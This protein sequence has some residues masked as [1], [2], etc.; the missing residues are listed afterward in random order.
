MSLSLHEAA[1]EK[2]DQAIFITGSARSG[3]T[4]MGK[5]IH[6]LQGV[7]YSFEPPT[8]FSLIPLIYQMEKAQWQLLFRTYLYEDFYVN[9]IS[10]RNLNFNP[11]DDSYILNAKSSELIKERHSASY[12]KGTID[13][14]SAN[15]NIALKMPDMV[16]FLAELNEFFP[17]LRLITMTRNPLAVINSLLHKAWYSDHALKN[18]NRVYPNR[19]YKSFRLPFWLK[20]EDYDYWLGLDEINRCAYYISVMEP[21]KVKND[22]I[23]VN[24]EAFVQSPRSTL[25]EICSQFGLRYGEKT[26]E[27]LATIKPTS[28]KVV[29]SKNQIIPELKARIGLA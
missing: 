6:S 12:R 10:G 8:L 24:Y 20:E 13:K 7:E 5:L 19:T 11:N 23:L 17:D 1:R 22:Q 15:G 4:I 25:D 9:A 14:Q 28:T 16:P 21:P 26:E 18:E 29:I 3:T 2:A 27:I